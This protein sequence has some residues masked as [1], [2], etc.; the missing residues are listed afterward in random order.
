MWWANITVDRLG[1]WTYAIQAW[2]DHFDT[3]CHDLRKRLAA[4]P[5][6]DSLDPAKRDMPPQ[7][8]PVA[9]NIGATL[10]DQA[11]AR[12]KGSDAS[13]L[14][15]IAGSLRMLA[16]KNLAFYDYPITIEIEELAERYP[17]LA[18]ASS[19][20]ELNLHG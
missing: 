2:V 16:E 1:K 10:L 18:F 13:Q 11:A 5:D 8:I 20:K 4:Q 12:A 6:P 17:D 7:D 3:W 14:K 19:S 15:A 9:F